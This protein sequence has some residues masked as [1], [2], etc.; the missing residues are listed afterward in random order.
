MKGARRVRAGG[1][2][3][4]TCTSRH[5]ASGLPVLT[6][7]DSAHPFGGQV[8]VQITRIGATVQVEVADAGSATTAPAVRAPTLDDDGGRGLWLVDLLATE[9]GFRRDETGGSVWFRLAER[10]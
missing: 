9:W 7:S 2:W 10:D 4:R 5:L 6:H 3:K 8:A 1:H